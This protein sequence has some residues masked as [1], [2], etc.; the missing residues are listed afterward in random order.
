MVDGSPDLGSLITSY[1]ITILPYMA[2]WAPRVFS[3]FRRVQMVNIEVRDSVY[4]ESETSA[5]CLLST[6]FL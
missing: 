1:Y 6:M 4:Q 2:T 5:E 3:F